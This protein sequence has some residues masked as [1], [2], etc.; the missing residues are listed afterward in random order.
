MAQLIKEGLELAQ[1]RM[2][3]L[4]NK[5]RTNRQFEVGDWVYLRLQPYRQ[6]SVEF[7]KN[8]N[9]AAMYYG[10]YQIIN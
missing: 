1:E 6:A 4:A 7:K 2:K 8:L 9:L 3:V 5:G 10:P